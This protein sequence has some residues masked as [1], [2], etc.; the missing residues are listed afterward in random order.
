ML[1]VCVQSVAAGLVGLVPSLAHAASPVLMTEQ[2]LHEDLRSSWQLPQ[3]VALCRMPSASVAYEDC[4]LEAE[5]LLKQLCPD[6]E[7][8]FAGKASALD[9]ESDD[10]AIEALS[11][12]L[13]K[14]EGGETD[15]Q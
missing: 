4:V 13:G 6:L 7:V 12:A 14:L 15:S 1:P 8:L 10:E 11:E 3:N 9:D 2:A 5:G